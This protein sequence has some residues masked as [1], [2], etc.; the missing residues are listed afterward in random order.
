MQSASSWLLCACC[1]Q[2][3]MTVIWGH[4]RLLVFPL[5]LGLLTAQ[6]I[7]PVP[8]PTLDS[9]C[10]PQGATTS[11]LTILRKQ[12]DWYFTEKT[13]TLDRN[14]LNSCLASWELIASGSSIPAKSY[15]LFV[16]TAVSSSS[17]THSFLNSLSSMSPSSGFFLPP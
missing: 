2:F 6:Q 12:F 8:S 4:V 1:E 10:S 17:E 9:G 13:G 5:L 3:C 16:L 14:F 7:W 11:S 15:V